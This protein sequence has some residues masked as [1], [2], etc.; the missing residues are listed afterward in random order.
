[1]KFILNKDYD[2][3]FAL[4]QFCLTQAQYE[5]VESGEGIQLIHLSLV[6]HFTLQFP[7][8]E[9]KS[10]VFPLHLEYAIEHQIIMNN[11]IITKNQN[12]HFFISFINY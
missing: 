5:F 12:H 6:G 10:V 9:L 2:A 1:L 7:I 11:K 3:I 4:G 8:K